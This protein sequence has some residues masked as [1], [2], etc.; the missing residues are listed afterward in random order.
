MAENI[1]HNLP[2]SR[3]ARIAANGLQTKIER[4][5]LELPLLPGV[6]ADVLALVENKDSDA[7]LLAKLVQSDQAL[8]G[9][10]MRIANSA[11]YSPSVPL[12]SLQQAIARLGM[13]LIAEIALAASIST[14]TLSA[15][16]YE[17]LIRQ[18]WQ[19]ALASALWSKEI[20][21]KVRKNVEATF[22]CGLLHQIGRPVVLQAVVDLIELYQLELTEKDIKLLIDAYHQETGSNIARHWKLPESVIEAINFTQNY[23]AAPT[24]KHLAMIVWAGNRFASLMM[25][26]GSITRGE[27][28]SLPVITD[29]NLYEDEVEALLE[30]T[31]GIKSAVEAL[32]V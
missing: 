5:E 23:N 8:A 15:P 18:M 6:A 14:K 7:M 11:H 22:L 16:G 4:D 19:H 27:L 9:H 26:D 20:A 29:L 25:N 1:H 10:V 21:R 12:V 13:T 3:N 24:V 2:L 31:T 30:A 17:H 32:F 28:F